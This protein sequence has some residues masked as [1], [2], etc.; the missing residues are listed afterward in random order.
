[1]LGKNKE[2]ISKKGREWYM[3]NC[4]LVDLKNK[5]REIIN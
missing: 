1:M 5:M 4:C 2:L 3:K